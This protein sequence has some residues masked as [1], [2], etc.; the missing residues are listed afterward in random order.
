MSYL[1]SVEIETQP[2]MA[3]Q[4]SVIWLHG[5]GANGY[6]FSSLVPEL[7]LPSSLAV[8]FIFPHAPEMPVTVNGGY[9]MPAWY[10]ILEMDF[11]RKVDEPQLRASA[12]AI[13][14]LIEREIE[15]GV[16][17]NKIALVGFS[18]G[19]AVVYEAGLSCAHGLAGI[20]VMSSYFATVNTLKIH[21]QNQQLPILIQHGSE[22]EV[23][24][25]AL[26]QRAFR[27]LSDMG[28]SVKYQSFSMGH[29]VCPEQVARIS[30][31]LQSLL[32]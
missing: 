15:R 13:Q 22:D 7:H 6:D 25:E 23:V 19:G 24:N 16:A 8:R 29:S 5:L 18:Q 3:A 14:A 11:E 4:A 9:V 30:I 27:Q 17:P 2:G 10:D 12:K 31:W 28:L 1:P 26:G 20:L 21:S 32:K